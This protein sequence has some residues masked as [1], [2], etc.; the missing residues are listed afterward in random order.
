MTPN[1]T[2][3]ALAGLVQEERE[4]LARLWAKRLREEL[5]ELDL[6]GRDLRAPLRRLLDELARLLRDRPDDVLRLWPEVVRSHGAF[7]YDQRFEPE[8]LVREFKALEEVL[9]RVYS[10]RH[11][12][13]LEPEVAE[14]ITE[15]VGEANASAQASYARVLRTEEV[16]FREAAVME[17][18]LYHMDVGILLVEADGT[19]S[20]ASPPVS[21]LMGVPMRSVVGA[22]ASASLA[23]VLTQV[24]ARHPAGEPFRVT[25]MPFM[26]ALQE[27]GPVRGGMMVVERPGGGEAWLEMSATPIW[28]EGGELVGVIQTI[29]DRTEAATKT[30]ELMSAQDELRRL[31]GRLLQRTRAQALGQLASGAAHALNNFLNVL[32][33]RITLLRRE[34]KPEH[35]DALDRTVGQIGELVARLQEFNVQRTEEVLKEVSLD[36]AVREALELA[37]GELERGEH[38]VG[39][40]LRLGDPGLVRADA[41]FL[42]EVVVSLLLAAR[43]RMQ[44]GG[45]LEL[46][47]QAEGPERTA[48][49]IQDEGPPYAVE[50]LARMFDPLNREAAAPQAALQLA[51]LRAQVQRWGGEL[52]V[53]NAQSGHGGAFV[54]RLP[55]ARPAHEVEARSEAPVT[56]PR[57]FQQT[58]RVLVVDDDMDN[59]RMLAEVLGDEGYDVQVAQ[60]AEVALQLWERR[61]FDA[62]LLDALMPDMSGWELAR[63]L[64]KRTPQ[65][66]LAIV[67]GMDVRGQSRDTLALVDAVFRKPI[68]LGALDEFL[69]QRDTSPSE[70]PSSAAPPG[71][72]KVGTSGLT[73]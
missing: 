35:L 68:E 57:R 56:G 24:T 52:T 31:Q 39:V 61:R 16:R 14:F 73:H 67:T 33:L 18:I 65:A 1:E 42:R 8:D 3:E 48:L 22:R 41:G 36:A 23:Q 51:V 7:R 29:T 25:D 6:P 44:A 37:R 9:L 4:R 64:R 59:A 5:Y 69:S 13:R 40:D 15:L 70:P 71:G 12:G 2:I 20:F 43:D 49:R 63:E 46:I 50:E 47:T 53:E 28:E 26:R 38:P 62:A 72:E 30:R 19:V 54:V 45:R 10:R 34:F 58:R 17:S 60:N 66:L 21:R 11:A 27:R 32:R 55:H